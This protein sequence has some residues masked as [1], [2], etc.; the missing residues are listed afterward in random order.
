VRNELILQTRQAVAEE[1]KQKKQPIGY[2]MRQCTRRPRGRLNHDCGSPSNCNGLEPNEV[3]AGEARTSWANEGERLWLL[4]G[5]GAGIM[6]KKKERKSMPKT[7]R[8]KLA[9]QLDFLGLGSL[10][11]EKIGLPWFWRDFCLTNF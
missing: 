11:L 2:L 7:K 3:S 1:K 9:R 8:R 6:R 4:R 5:R 10:A